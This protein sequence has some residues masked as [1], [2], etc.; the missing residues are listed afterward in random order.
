M[1]LASGGLRRKPGRKYRVLREYFK[2]LTNSGRRCSW[3]ILFRV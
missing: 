3:S 2:A 1:V